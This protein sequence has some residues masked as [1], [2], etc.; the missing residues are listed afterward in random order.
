MEIKWYRQFIAELVLHFR[1]IEY[2]VDKILKSSLEQEE[3]FVVLL[4]VLIN[5]DVDEW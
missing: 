4:S 2:L 1:I 3:D 5:S